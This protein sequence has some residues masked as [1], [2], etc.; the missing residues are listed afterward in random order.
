M[1]IINK[2]EKKLAIKGLTFR[3]FEHTDNKE[4]C[5]WVDFISENDVLPIG[6]TIRKEIPNNEES[7]SLYNKVNS[8]FIE[9]FNGLHVVI[10]ANN[11]NEQVNKIRTDY[12]TAF[13]KKTKIE[14]LKKRGL[15]DKQ[16]IQFL[17]ILEDLKPTE[18]DYEAFDSEMEEGIPFEGGMSFTE[19]LT[20]L[21]TTL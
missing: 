21:K 4:L 20:A 7:I 13:G 10:T 2:V 11:I 5:S 3:S 6:I 17:S 14:S 1:T 18:E 19:A 9:K 16:I 15:T 8:D 12:M